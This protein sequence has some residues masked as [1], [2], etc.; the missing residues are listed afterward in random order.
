MDIK[1]NNHWNVFLKSSDLPPIVMR[2]NF[3]WMRPIPD[4]DYI[5]YDG[6]FYHVSEFTGLPAGMLNDSSWQYSL[7]LASGKCLLL[8]R[9]DCGG[10]YKIGLW[11]G[12]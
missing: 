12:F 2:N 3:A 9:S 11:R 6:G 5:K 1:T 8:S 4:T 7:R 10:R